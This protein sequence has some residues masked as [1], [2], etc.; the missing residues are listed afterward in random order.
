MEYRPKVKV[1]SWDQFDDVIND[2]PNDGDIYYIKDTGGTDMYVW[3]AADEC[4][5]KVGASPDNAEKTFAMGLYDMNKSLIEQLGPLD[6]EK[7]SEKH[8][9]INTFKEDNNGTF[10]MLYGKEISYFTLFVCGATEPELPDLA[11]GV[12]DCLT[13]VGEVYSIEQTADKSAIEI[14]IKVDGEM[15]CMYLFPYD[16][17]IVTVGG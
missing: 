6:L 16:S 14:W 4:L 9:L 8:D 15:T 1:I 7:Y 17:G 12:F 11:A 13:N 2:N 5:A 3:N 10:F